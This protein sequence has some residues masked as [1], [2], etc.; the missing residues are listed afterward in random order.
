LTWFF[1]VDHVAD[2]SAMG[3]PMFRFVNFF[4]KMLV[5]VSLSVVVAGRGT[6]RYAVSHEHVRV[7]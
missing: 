3:N 1:S 6:V 2:L 7:P 4:S 5:L